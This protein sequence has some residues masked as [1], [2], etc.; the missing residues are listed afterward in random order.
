M[1]SETIVLVRETLTFFPAHLG[2]VDCIQAPIQ[3]HASLPWSWILRLKMGLPLCR[4]HCVIVLTCPIRLGLIPQG[5]P[6]TK[7]CAQG[8]ACWEVAIG[9]CPEAGYEVWDN[10][11]RFARLI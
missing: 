4:A 8:G 10:W 1:S 5:E 7:H 9:R 3:M 11:S 2:I 6:L